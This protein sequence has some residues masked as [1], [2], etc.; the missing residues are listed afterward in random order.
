METFDSNEFR[1]NK[2]EYKIKPSF[3][4]T[5]HLIKMKLHNALVIVQVSSRHLVALHQ[6]DTIET[7]YEAVTRGLV[8]TAIK[9]YRRVGNRH[10][11]YVTYD[12]ATLKI[13]PDAF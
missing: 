8:L 13:I 7:A 1:E 6:V 12:N 4:I 2:L 10:I 11:S 9:A 5:I 3:V